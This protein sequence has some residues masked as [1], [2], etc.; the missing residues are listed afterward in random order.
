MTPTD[1]CPGI[2][3]IAPYQRMARGLQTADRS[4]LSR[5]PVYAVTGLYWGIRER[6]PLVFMTSL[7][8]VLAQFLPITLANVPYDLTQTESTNSICSRLSVALLAVMICALFGMLFVSFPPLPVDPRS[9]AG[10]MWYVADA[11]WVS[12]LEGVTLMTGKERERRMEELG[13]RWY[14]G[15][16]DTRVGNRMTVEMMDLYRSDEYGRY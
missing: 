10:A 16:A 1:P 5:R 6:D 11:R 12:K 2:A 8:A 3:T 14:Y 7:M 15:M 13:G 9:V 4:V